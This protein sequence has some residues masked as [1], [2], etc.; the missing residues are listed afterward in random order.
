MALIQAE[1]WGWVGY[2]RVEDEFIA[3]L[4]TEE[5]VPELTHPLSAGC[6]VTRRCN[7]RCAYC[8]GNLE[9]L[10]AD[11]LDANGWQAVFKHLRELGVMRVDLS[12][13][14]PTIRK[15]IGDIAVAAVE[16][17]LNVVLSTNG[18]IISD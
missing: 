1:Q 17:D 5:S 12:G 2:N 6:L 7:Y 11:S 4:R 18:A 9:G 16:E 14:E 8:Y 15:D 3:E 13:G 10:P